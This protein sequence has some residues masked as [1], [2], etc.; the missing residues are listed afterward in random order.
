M[1]FIA[2]RLQTTADIS[3][4]TRSFKGWLNNAAA[5]LFTIVLLYFLVGLLIDLVVTNISEEGEAQLFSWTFAA[6]ALD[7]DDVDNDLKRAQAVFERLIANSN[8]RPLP[9][10]LFLLDLPDANALAFPGGGT[11]ITRK[12]LKRVESEIGLAMVL[13]HELGHH[14]DRHSMKQL[15][16]TLVWN[17]LFNFIFGSVD[18]SALEFMLHFAN[19][20]YG[21]EQERDAD[22]F[23][24]RLVHEV[25]G[26]TQ[27]ALEFFEL[28]QAELAQN[29]SE[30]V[31]FMS[32][33]PLTGNRI[34]DLTE[35]QQQLN[36]E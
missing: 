24:L 34:A 36:M 27:G 1:K 7:S 12:L 6:V 13:A 2:K 17:T 20:G 18:V 10:E 29:E 31:E 25:Y 19:T 30:W 8:V 28:V 33:H 23:G 5:G 11:G 35:L 22:E 9:Y 16:R 4:G 32:T 21:R 3:R 15:G 26:Q 14:E